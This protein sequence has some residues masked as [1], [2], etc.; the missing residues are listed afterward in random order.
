MA[1][2]L[3]KFRHWQP[4]QPSEEE[5]AW[6]ET[7]KMKLVDSCNLQYD[8]GLHA[9]RNDLFSKC[10]HQNSSTVH[11]GSCFSACVKNSHHAQD[12]PTYTFT[13]PHGLT[14]VTPSRQY[15]YYPLPKV[16]S[17]GLRMSFINSAYREYS[18]L[19][20]VRDE[21][22]AAEVVRKDEWF[23]CDPPD[24]F[25]TH[26]DRV[27]CGTLTYTVVRDPL[28]RFA[29][30][31]REVCGYEKAPVKREWG[32]RILNKV[33]GGFLMCDPFK[34]TN[35]SS[36]H[37]DLDRTVRSMACGDWNEHLVPQS[38]ILRPAFEGNLDI[39]TLDPPSGYKTPYGFREKSKRC[40]DPIKYVI[41]LRDIG[42]LS[43]ILLNSTGRSFVSTGD[44]M[45][46]R[47]GWPQP[48]DLGRGLSDE[49][50]RVWCLVHLEDYIRFGR[51][52]CPPKWC[53][54]AL[55]ALGLSAEF[56]RERFQGCNANPIAFE[57]EASYISLFPLW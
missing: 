17:S 11:D 5:L 40:D 1:Q 51:F 18:D 25:S 15:A 21:R 45:N 57:R 7:A 41:P 31:Y 43:E 39:E 9:A 27:P 42:S 22:K 2:S 19:M 12:Y 52:F 16:A 26:W 55:Q 10:L 53:A 34:Q 35:E 28:K 30:G 49:G 50:K 3:G 38:V 36:A 24:M 20:S 32:S 29:S 13:H 46:A 8:F 47:K 4:R 48:I 56:R 33:M 6:I 14:Y 44:V 54:K 37:R 23:H